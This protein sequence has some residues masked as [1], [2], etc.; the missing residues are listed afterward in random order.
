MLIERHLEENSDMD[1]R[2]KVED[3]VFAIKVSAGLRKNVF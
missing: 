2:F 3:V 1:K